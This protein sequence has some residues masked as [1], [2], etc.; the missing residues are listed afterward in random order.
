MWERQ[1]AIKIARKYDEH[2]RQKQLQEKILEDL[3]INA[4]RK[5]TDEEKNQEVIR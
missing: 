4:I 2:D 1:E 3:S 5:I